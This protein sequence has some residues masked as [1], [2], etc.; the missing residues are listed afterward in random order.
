[1]VCRF[2]HDEPRHAGSPFNIEN[3]GKNHARALIDPRHRVL[4]NCPLASSAVPRDQLV[5][6]P[7]NVR[8]RSS[9]RRS[10][11]QQPPKSTTFAIEAHITTTNH[12]CKIIRFPALSA[13]RQE[14]LRSRCT[15]IS[16]RLPRL[17]PGREAAPDHRA[18]LGDFHQGVILASSPT[19]THPVQ[20][21]NH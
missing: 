1:M 15:S 16:L 7:V 11:D 17:R 12:G 13:R 9:R 10:R 21:V 2:R 18:P 20:N 14:P 5:R 8:V 19:Q 3:H 4:V 6:I